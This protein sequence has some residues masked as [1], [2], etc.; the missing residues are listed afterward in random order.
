MEGNTLSSAVADPPPYAAPTATDWLVETLDVVAV[1]VAAVEPAGTATVCGTA[2]AE[3]LLLKPTLAPPLG[4]AAVSPTVQ[5]TEAPPVTDAGL[6][7]SDESAGP[8]PDT[9]IAPPVPEIVIAVPVASTPETLLR[10][11]A[12]LEA[13][14]EK[15]IEAI[16]PPLIGLEFVP[17]TRHV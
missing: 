3:L 11:I 1:K 14:P 6:Q 8:P 12:V 7:L 13:T 16:T 2:T 15:V 4:A 9:E 17:L 5:L 10:E